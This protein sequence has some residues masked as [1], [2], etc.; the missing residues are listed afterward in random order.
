M[1]NITVGFPIFGLLGLLFIYLKL[2]GTIAWS[3]WLV[4]LPLYGPAAVALVFVA[5]FVILYWLASR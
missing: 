4:L 1:K 3:W 2:T 5:L